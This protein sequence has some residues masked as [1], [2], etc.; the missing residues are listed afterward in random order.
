MP[1][2]T[3]RAAASESWESLS[4]RYFGEPSQAG[5]IKSANPGV[6]DVFVPG[7]TIII[8]SDADDN[9][10]T[11]SDGLVIRIGGVA[12]QN[13][14]KFSMTR[15][16]DAV[17][18]VSITAPQ[19]ETEA[20]SDLITPFSFQSLDVAEAGQRIF[21]GTMV[22]V[23]PSLTAEKSQVVLSAYSLPGVL[24]DCTMP[25]TDKPIAFRNMNLRDIAAELVEPFSIKLNADSDVG[26]PFRR[27]KL[28]R[29]DRVLPF[30]GNLAKQR[31]ILMRSNAAGEL[32][33]A[34][35]P[36]ISAPVAKLDESKPPVLKITPAF[37]PQNYHSH[38]TV[39]RLTRK[40]KPGGKHTI[41]NPLAVDAGIV[42]PISIS[43]RDVTRGEL[44]KAAAAKAGA[45]LANS[46]SYSVQIP[47]WRDPQGDMWEPG[48]TIELLAP[49]VFVRTSYQ[50]QI[51]SVKFDRDPEKDLAT[52][53]LMLPGAYGGVAPSVLPWQ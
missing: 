30:L 33:L 25:T 49:S 4:I 39:T 48:S 10:G 47:G 6:S 44:P 18:T 22:G 12:F 46:L 38:V 29:E 2:K 19:A 52:L 36:E 37:N 43:I 5:R 27:V 1:N 7:A 28:K 3:H 41:V 42:R 17:D 35:P 34:G 31:Q 9:L 21:R 14:S 15:Q 53:N 23:D 16:I 26:G 20:F 11:E 24:T 40:G 50:F 45:M 32:V 51:R 13:I 8:P